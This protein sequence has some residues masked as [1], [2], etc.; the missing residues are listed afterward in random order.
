MSSVGRINMH[1]VSG[2]F[3]KYASDPSHFVSNKI[4]K[5]YNN[6]TSYTLA[7]REKFIGCVHSFIFIFDWRSS[8]FCYFYLY[9]LC[10]FLALFRTFG[11]AETVI[12]SNYIFIDKIIVLQHDFWTQK[13]YI[14][15]QLLSLYIQIIHAF[16]IHF[17]KHTTYKIE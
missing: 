5:T 8:N 12:L 3:P 6:Y 13:R 2:F 17:S 1:I 14:S 16:C 15:I 4:V 11:G 9:I 7:I 10:L